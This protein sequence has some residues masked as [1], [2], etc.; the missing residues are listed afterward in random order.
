MPAACAAAMTFSS[1][2]TFTSS[3]SWRRRRQMLTSAAACADRVAAGRCAFQCGA[4]AHVAV[5]ERAGEAAGGRGACEHNEIVPARGERP[6]DRASKVTGATGHK[7]FHPVEGYVGC[8]GLLVGI[9]PVRQQI[10]ERLFE[11]NLRAP[12]KLVVNARRIAEQQRRIVRPIARRVLTGSSPARA[13]ARS[14]AR[15][16]RR[17]AIARPEQTLYGRPGCAVLEDQAVGAHG[18]ADVGQIAPGVEIADRDFRRPP[19]AL[20]CRRSA[21]RSPTATNMRI[22]PR[23]EMVE[24]PRDHHLAHRSRVA[25]RA[26]PARAC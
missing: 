25:R 7:D 3:K 10:V 19:S 14:A 11:R 17:C 15:A 5:D 26:V 20:R 2:P 8:A 4:V 6:D 13:R 9:P 1:P 18:V 23:T 24:R 21:A 22:L 16:D 12:P